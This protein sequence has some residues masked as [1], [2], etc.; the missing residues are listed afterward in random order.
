MVL[1]PVN[2]LLVMPISK[3]GEEQ[4]F[5]NENFLNARLK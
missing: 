2:Q 1:G 5:G 3:A 4:D